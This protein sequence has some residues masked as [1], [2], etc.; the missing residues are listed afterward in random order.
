VQDLE[1]WKSSSPLHFYVRYKL[2]EKDEPQPVRWDALYVC[3]DCVSKELESMRRTERFTEYALK[4]PLPTLDL[5]GGVGAFGL[6]LKN[7]SQ[8]LAITHAIEISPSAAQTYECASLYSN[9]FSLL[10]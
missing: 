1:A 9:T 3:G 2:N 8:A 6:G 4:N 5:F 7:G 10:T